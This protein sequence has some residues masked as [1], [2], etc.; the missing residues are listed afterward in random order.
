MRKLLISLLA[1]SSTASFAVANNSEF[2][3]FLNEANIGWGMNQ[4]VSSFGTSPKAPG[5]LISTG[6]QLN[7][8]AERL[9]N[10]GVWVDA[11]ANMQFAAGPTAIP[12]NAPSY[13]LNG[14]VGYAFPLAN[15]HLL[16]TPYGQVGMNNNSSTMV[17]EL[18][19]TTSTPGI[20][21]N[22]YVW[23]AGVGGRIEYR[24][25]R[26]ID[27]YGDQNIV[28]NW[29]QTGMTLGIMPQNFMSLTS[30]IGARFNLAPNFQL[31]VR[32]Y[33]TNYQNLASNTILGVPAFAQNN[34]TIGAL[35]TLGLTY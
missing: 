5:N 4:T 12:Y 31:G 23:T 22:D 28:Y 13:G 24:I 3:E 7:L 1:V 8:E 17:N 11:V 21:A 6:N 27:I 29:D 18:V 19:V 32:G 10:S 15:Q 25:N 35:V 20:T 26:W 14:K 34:S 30:M 16:I 33:Y 9:F 2:Q